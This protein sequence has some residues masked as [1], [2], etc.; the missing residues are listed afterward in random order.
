MNDMKKALSLFLLAAI[1]TGAFASCSETT[2]EENETKSPVSD[3][4]DG[5]SDGESEEETIDVMAYLGEKDYGGADFVVSGRGSGSGEWEN[6]EILAE[7]INAEPINDAVYARNLYL[8]ET[9]GVKLI[10]YNTNNYVGEFR[11]A[12]NANTSDFQ[13]GLMPVSNANSLAIEGCLYDFYDLPVVELTNP[14][15]DQNANESLSI[16][17]RLYNSFGNMN[18]QNIDLT[19]CVMFNKELAEQQQLGNLYSLV[20]N[21]EWTMDKLFELTRGFT[22]DADGNGVMNEYDE[23]GMATPFDR[24]SYA[25]MYAGGVQYV[26]KDEED[27]PTYNALSERTYTI[28]SQIL[29]FYHTDDSCLNINTL[30]GTW[31]TAENM[32]MNN[33]ILF[34]VECMQNL[35]RFRDMEVD[36]G[37]LPMPKYSADQDT[38]INMVC[39]FPAALVVPSNTPDAEFTGFVVEAMNA[40]SSDTVRVAY[41]NKCLEYKYSRDQESSGMVTM[42]LDNMYYDPAY[43][44]GWGGLNDKI[45]VLISKNYDMLA[46]QAKS[47]EKKILADIKETVDA[48]KENQ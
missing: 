45:G 14:W 37:V 46:S 33:Q 9:Y 4:S 35:S 24:T 17:G 34:Y 18:I 39:D 16:G 26:T 38:Y 42:I 30:S 41:V 47:I 8:E 6:F 36:F 15:Y 11:N 44:Y 28:F 22:N 2:T 20:E 40:K 27:Y 21:N 13:A 7:E 5:T 29:S 31:R 19:W 43:F 32:F 1:L 3:T 23:Y 25:F 10:A 12:V 48:Y